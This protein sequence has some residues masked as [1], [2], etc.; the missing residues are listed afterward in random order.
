MIDPRETDDLSHDAP[1]IVIVTEERSDGKSAHAAGARPR[2]G[3]G[4]LLLWIGCCAVFLG[5]AR[6]AA[7]RPPGTVGALFLTL[8]GAGYGA[9]WAGLMITLARTLRGAPWSIEPGQWLLAM[10]GVVGGVEVL[11]EI[12]SPRWLSDPRAVVEATAACAFVAPLLDRR[13]EPWWKWLFGALALAHALPLL[14]ALAGQMNGPLVRTA[15]L[16]SPGPLTATTAVAALALALFDRVRFA[17]HRRGEERGWLHWTGI[18]T[19]LW[20]PLL[21]LAGGLLSG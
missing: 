18:A 11:G 10:L 21:R 2:L 4:H 17:R 5:L 6:G 3:I 20:L 9:A 12:L 14:I 19:A 15:A 8:V 16:F 13:L 1:D 7:E